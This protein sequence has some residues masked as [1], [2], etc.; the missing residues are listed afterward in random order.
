MTDVI[1][2]SRRPKTDILNIKKVII[3]I[4]ANLSHFSPIDE[5]LQPSVRAAST[6][7]ILPESPRPTLA[8]AIFMKFQFVV[9]LVVNYC[10]PERTDKFEMSKRFAK[11]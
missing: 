1:Q 2:R 4:D 5:H 8:P 6:T 10:M 7:K 9:Y 11:L 3:N